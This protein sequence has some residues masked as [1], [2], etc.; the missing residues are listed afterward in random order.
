MKNRDRFFERYTQESQN[1]AAELHTSLE[2]ALEKLKKMS[3]GQESDALRE[4]VVAAA[5]PFVRRIA[6]EYKTFFTNTMDIIQQGNEGLLVAIQRFDSNRSASFERYAEYWIRCKV[7]DFIM[8]A[9]RDVRIPRG[10]K[11]MQLLV[12]LKKMRESLA[13][14]GLET[15]AS[16][17]ADELDLDEKTK[18]RSEELL[19]HKE[20][21]YHTLPPKKG[22]RSRSLGDPE[23]SPEETVAEQE[24]IDFVRKNLAK[25][26]N[27][28]S[29]REKIILDEYFF[30]DP[31]LTQEQIGKKINVSSDRVREIKRQLLNKLGKIFLQ[32]QGSQDVPLDKQGGF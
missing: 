20:I 6:A 11:G 26:K 27:R 25:I 8:N 10:K 14:Q 4:A 29:Y 32:N 23:I 21:P 19:A 16:A 9:R 22:V 2:E 5:Q 28:L 15:T 12:A 1:K 17:L 13:L 24:L 30:R 31:P 3:P 7:L 18:A